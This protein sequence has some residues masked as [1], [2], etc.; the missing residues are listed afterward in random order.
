MH[1]EIKVTIKSK[2]S[3]IKKIDFPKIEIA[4]HAIPEKG[5]ANKEL[6]RFLSEYIGIPKSQIEILQGTTSRIKQ[7][8]ISF[9]ASQK[10]EI[11]SKFQK[12][13]FE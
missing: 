9:N 8:C 13:D 7:I 10:T 3:R 6:I 2:I 5:E 4:I 1:L 11:E 12:L